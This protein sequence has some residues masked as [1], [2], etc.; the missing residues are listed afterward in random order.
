[1]TN[2]LLLQHL[3][4]WMWLK[5]PDIVGKTLQQQHNLE[6]VDQ[7]EASLDNRKCHMLRP[8]KQY[9]VLKAS[10]SEV[11]GDEAHLN[12]VDYYHTNDGK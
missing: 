11:C 4:L 7:F 12:V 5:L 10:N 1:M 2:Y 8:S 9:H 3:N 6:E